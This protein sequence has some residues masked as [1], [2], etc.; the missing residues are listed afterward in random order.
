MQSSTTELMEM[1]KQS[2]L[3]WSPTRGSNNLTDTDVDTHRLSAAGGCLKGASSPGGNVRP[4]CPLSGHKPSAAIRLRSQSR[5]VRLQILGGEG[6][7]QGNVKRSCLR[8][9]WRRSWAVWQFGCLW[10]LG[11]LAP[12]MFAMFPLLG[13]CS[14]HAANTSNCK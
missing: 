11:K 12:R 2:A 14:Q 5:D 6:R 3:C 10:W 8:V 9:V 4:V 7:E 1:K 13:K